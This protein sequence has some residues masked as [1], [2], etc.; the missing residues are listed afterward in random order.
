MEF[1][2]HWRTNYARSRL[3]SFYREK[4]SLFPDKLKQLPLGGCFLLSVSKKSFL[5]AAQV[6]ETLKKFQKL[7]ISMVRDTLLGFPSHIHPYRYRKFCHFI[8]ILAYTI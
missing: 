2:R 8:D 3:R 4:T 7:L 1:V 6:F 5:P